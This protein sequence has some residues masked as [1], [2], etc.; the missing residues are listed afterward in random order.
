[1]SI[2]TAEED[3]TLRGFRIAERR[4]TGL[5]IWVDDAGEGAWSGE[6][7]ALT[8]DLLRLADNGVKEFADLQSRLTAA[9]QQVAELTEERDAMA[10]AIRNVL[11]VYVELDGAGRKLPLESAS[12]HYLTKERMISLRDSLPVLA[13]QPLDGAEPRKT[14][15]T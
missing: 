13:A 6:V 3:E 11:A 10:T 5:D 2:Y 1:M 14:P 7:R 12:G 8:E 15:L 4:A 9:E